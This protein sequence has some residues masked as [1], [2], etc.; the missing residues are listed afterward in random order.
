M[1]KDLQDQISSKK[2]QIQNVMHSV[3]KP[4][5]FGYAYMWGNVEVKLK[6]GKSKWY[7]VCLGGYCAGNHEEV[8]KAVESVGGVSGVYY[9]L[10]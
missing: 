4:H 8:V 1:R 3:A 6:N 10:D 9:N 7:K 2:S 5:A